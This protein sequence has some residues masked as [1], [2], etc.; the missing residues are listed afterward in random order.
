MTPSLAEAT[1]PRT[2]E[3]ATDTAGLATKLTH[4]VVRDRISNTKTDRRE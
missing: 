4:R 3:S 2:G 1:A